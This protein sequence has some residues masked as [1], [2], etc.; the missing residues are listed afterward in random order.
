MHGVNTNPAHTR[1]VIVIGGSAG[2]LEALLH[3]VAEL[4][5]N[6][7]AAVLVV[8]HIPSHTPSKLHTIL[9]RVAALP[10]AA[11]VDGEAVLPGRIYVASADR[12]LMIDQANIRLTRGPRECRVRPAI[13]VLFRSA[14]YHFGPRV[15]GVVLSGT[16][17]DGTAGLWAIKDRGGLTLVQ[18]PEDA[19]YDSMPQSALD[20][21]QVDAVLPAAE[22]PALLAQWTQEGVRAGEEAPRSV[23][24][25][26]EQRI[27]LEENA[28]QQGVL[29]LGP[30][31][32]NTC[33]E[34][35]GAMVQ[36]QEGPIVRYRCH[37][38]HAYS[39]QSL[40]AEITESIDLQLWNSL[41]VIE[42]RIL[43]L[44]QMTQ[45]AT[46]EVERAEC[47]RQLQW[48]EV[49]MD[50]LRRLAMSHHAPE[51]SPTDVNSNGGEDP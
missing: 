2:G 37:T 25:E 14:A 10:V 42:E 8:L 30:F 40:L 20:H 41:R 6:L 21:V 46:R 27:A 48:A 19:L 13:D 28:L 34:C 32:P 38:G 4:P 17:D 49:R 44:R 35:H 31:S 33:P 24:M 47:L 43:V 39:M 18:S 5:A 7:A 1:D 51:Y 36:I 9:A 22:M 11:A 23:R 26:I 12:H 3:L 50:A 15:I 29:K 16:L 45:Q